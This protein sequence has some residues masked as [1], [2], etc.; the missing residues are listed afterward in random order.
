MRVLV[1]EDDPDIASGLELALRRAGYI[2][3]VHN[4]GPDGENQAFLQS[5]GAILL[6]WMLPGKS[7]AEVCRSLR[8][9]GIKAPILMVTARDEVKDRVKGL[10]CGADDY[11]VKPFAIEELLARIR[12]LTRRE[13]TQKTV[14]LQLG[15]IQL[16]TQAKSVT[17]ADQP[18]HLT[19]REYAL[20]EAL[21]RNPGRVYSREA[22]L[23]NVW[24]NDEAL[25]NTVNFHVS[26]LRR[27]V[28]PDS[29]YIRTLHGFGYVMEN[30]DP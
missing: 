12:A 30:R 13:S 29:K 25:P 19:H 26:S 15:N 22:I 2:V 4:N 11:L 21:M 24:N 7:G 9:A 10:D 28:D 23:E 27:K 18:V 6:D 1:V 14:V 3:D 20:L 5:Y 8:A 17:V 16:D